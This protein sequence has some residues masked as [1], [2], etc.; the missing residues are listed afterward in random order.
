MRDRKRG[1]NRVSQRERENKI[2]RKTKRKR[3]W[4]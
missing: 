3:D 4:Y 2:N 1:R